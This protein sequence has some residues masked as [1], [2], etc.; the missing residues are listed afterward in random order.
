MLDILNMYLSSACTPELKSSIEIAHSVFDKIHLDAYEQGYEEILMLDGTVDN[1]TTLT[2][3]VNLTKEIQA[4]VLGEHEVVLQEDTSIDIYTLFII[5]L[6]QIQIYENKDDIS[7]LTALAI[8]PEEI[9]AEL[10]A[11][12]IE[13]NADEL[14]PHIQSVSQF[15][16]TRIAELAAGVGDDISDEDHDQQ[17]RH[18][19]A[20]KQFCD[21]I[22]T[23]PKFISEIIEQNVGVGYPF[24]IYANIIKD[25]LDH[26][27]MVVNN[28]DDITPKQA[29][30]ELIAACLISSD[31]ID[32]I[33]ST[34]KEHI[35]KLISDINSITKVDIA[36]S[37]I[38]LGFKIQS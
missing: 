4:R 35:D 36:V 6:Y 17:L 11:L 8:S 19:K 5:G 38:L 1:D 16:I 31:G 7:K 15:L 37:D 13:K 33:R 10:M 24:I 3:I 14:L 34:I 9:F 25:H 20:F 30:Y 12:V 2:R 22:E 26:V 32:N 27:V 28:P 21:Y 23:K 18:I 29:A